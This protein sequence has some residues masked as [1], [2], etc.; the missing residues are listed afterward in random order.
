M[1]ARSRLPAE[2]GRGGWAAMSAGAEESDGGAML[3]GKDGDGVRAAQPGVDRPF[4][5]ARGG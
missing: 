5:C 2:R 1:A 3:T 4:Y